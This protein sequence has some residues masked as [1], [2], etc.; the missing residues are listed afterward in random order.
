MKKNNLGMSLVEIIIVIAIL[1]VIAGT[2]GLGIGLMTGKP[3]EKCA[4]KLNA[5]MQNNRM[6]TMGKL[7]ARLEI[8]ID[9]E[10]YICV[11]EFVETAGEGEKVTTTRIG[12]KGVVLR[13]KISGEPDYRELNTGIPL[14]ISFNRSSGAFHDLSAMGSSYVDKYCIEIEVSKGN[15][16]KLLKLSYLT[17]K[18]TLE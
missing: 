12:D 7:S 6:T 8:Y 3:A 4:R 13:Y 18:I 2:V 15:T 1:A 10:G 11:N 9:A 16:V 5:M 14:I 17:G